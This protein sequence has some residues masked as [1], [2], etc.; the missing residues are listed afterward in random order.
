V[1][2]TG[3]A[4][5]IGQR[6]CAYLE[7]RGIVVTRAARAVGPGLPTGRWVATGD[8]AECQQL[9]RLL[10]GHDVIV[11]LAGRAHVMGTPGQRQP[12]DFFRDNADVTARLARAAVATGIRRFVFVSTVGVHGDRSQ[13]PLV[14][15]DAL[16]PVGAYA[17]SKLR[18]EQ[19]LH[20][21][22]GRH[23]LET[24]ILRPTLTYGP[25]CPGNMAR[26]ARLVARGLPLPLLNFDSRRSLMGL[27]NLVTLLEAT[28]SHPAAA[29]ETF[30]AA[31]GEDICLTD[32]VRH[33]ARGMGV[34]TRLFP[35]PAAAA[36]LAAHA[37]GLGA[38]FEKLTSSLTVDIHKARRFLGWSPHVP[39]AV[40]LQATGRSFARCLASSAA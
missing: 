38:A 10:H 18:A 39:V 7:S 20:D 8:L 40:G 36:S 22:A 4:G 35:F 5:F 6:L 23:A 15:S 27:E 17:Q 19:M 13:R 9:P 29:G 3:A 31:D 12:P 30:L 21:I 33:L 37:V 2:V 24:V 34:T 28:L 1:F 16:A 32:I 25:N 26:L 14:E 11:H